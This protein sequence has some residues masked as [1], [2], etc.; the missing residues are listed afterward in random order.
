MSRVWSAGC[1]R[2]WILSSIVYYLTF[3]RLTNNCRSRINGWIYV[4]T[5]VCK[6]IT[7]VCFVFFFL[8]YSPIVKAKYSR[9][10][11]WHAL[12]L[13]QVEN[14]YISL[15]RSFNEHI[16]AFH[17]IKT[18]AL[19]IERSHKNVIGLVF[20][21]RAPDGQLYMLNVRLSPHL[22]T[23]SAVHQISLSDRTILKTIMSRIFYA[24]V[25]PSIYE[26]TVIYD[27]ASV[28]DRWICFLYFDGHYGFHRFPVV[29]SFCLFI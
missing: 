3:L 27:W 13:G 1:Y 16:V 23:D 25:H 7:I 15:A 26:Y 24:N 11:Y 19:I 29:D 9:L 28:V 4:G 20:G 18:C 12:Y 14:Q 17:L 22:L 21:H 10:L 8:F 2:R 5:F 6:S